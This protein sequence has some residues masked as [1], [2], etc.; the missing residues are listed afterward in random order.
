M[1]EHTYSLT[2]AQR[3]VWFTELLEPDTSICNLTACVKFK[4]NIEL[5]TLEGALNHSISRLF[6]KFHHIIM[7]GISLNVMGNQIIDLY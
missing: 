1:S 7:D 6:A 2:H 5:D 4:G 3:R